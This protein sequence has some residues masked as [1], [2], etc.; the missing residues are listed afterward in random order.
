MG[1]E[2]SA[3]EVS[4]LEQRTEGWIVGLQLAAL[5]LQGHE[6]AAGFVAAFS[7]DDRYIVDYLLEEVLQR[8]PDRV[9]HFL[10]QTAVLERL[11][12][13]LCDAVTGQAGGQ[14]M[15]EALSVATCLSFR[16]ITSASGTDTTSLFCRCYSGPCPDGV[17]RTDTQPARTS[18]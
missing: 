1:L 3:A 18:K 11:S 15:L 2:I 7:G 9:R 6:D 8:Q 14:E 12:G 17:A 4:A 13:S 5:S 16:W 10:L